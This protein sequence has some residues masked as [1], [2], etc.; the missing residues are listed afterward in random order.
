[1]DLA[2]TAAGT[3]TESAGWVPVDACTLPT[4]QQPLRVAEFD[5]LFAEALH[6][7]H[8]RPGSAP[9]ARLVLVGN[10]D[11]LERVQ[12]LVDVE[13]ACCS[14]FTLTRRA[15]GRDVVGADGTALALDVEVPVVHAD[16]LAGLI[17][18]AQRAGGATA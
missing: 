15:L 16:V 5:E 13:T 11:L 6:S 2:G 3:L 12:R 7:V 4:S 8:R 9:R 17:D 1:M 10:E 18:R 14:F